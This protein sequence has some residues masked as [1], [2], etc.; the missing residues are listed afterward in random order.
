M[1]VES[2]LAGRP[3][4]A[5]V[6]GLGAG[7]AHMSGY[8]KA[9]GVDLVAIAG[10]E[11]ERLA[12]AAERFNVPHTFE[13]WEYLVAREDI[14]LVSIATPNALHA[15][16][17]IAALRAGK[18]V[19][20]EK[21]LSVDAGSAQQM[22]DGAVDAGRVLQTAFNF[23]RRGDVR[24]L[25]Q[26]LDTGALG[27]IYHTKSTWLRRSGI[28]GL[29]SWFTSKDLAGG[30]PLIDLGVHVLDLAL[31]LLDEPRVVSVTAATYAELGGR[32]RGGSGSSS[33]R[34]GSG[35]G[36]TYQVEDLA[37]AFLRFEDGGSLRLEAAWASYSKAGDDIEIQL[38]GTDGGAQIL[39][40]DYI[41]ENT[42]RIFTD[43]GGQ[44]AVT[45]PATPPSTG[46]TGVV[47]D[48][49][50]AVRE[51]N[52]AAHVGLDGLRRAQ[53]IDACYASAREG[54]EIRL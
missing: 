9:D 1:T 44:P 26:H 8:V 32:G 50:A 37:T 35:T 13:D 7:Q 24:T 43:V 6:I 10:K 38:M 51:G 4:R 31:Y 54:R 19:L 36:L 18:H 30:G 53:V 29:G 46:H 2:V 20:C 39:I 40:E 25:R 33:A 16:I 5:G 27:R 52:W 42:L 48:F 49:V 12:S 41:D 28:P 3:L 11:K 21:P 34:F 45:Y 22:V 23:R 47:A 14:D 15:P 17:A